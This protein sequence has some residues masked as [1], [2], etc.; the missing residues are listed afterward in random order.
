MPMGSALSIKAAVI[1]CSSSSLA[2][3][4]L[5]LPLYRIHDLSRLQIA[6]TFR[7]SDN[8][9][10]RLAGA[11][12]FSWI[13]YLPQLEHSIHSLQLDT[14]LDGLGIRSGAR[15]S[16][17]MVAVVFTR[18]QYYYNTTFPEPVLGCNVMLFFSRLEFKS[19]SGLEGRML[20]VA[21]V[22]TRIQV[23]TTHV[24][25][26]PFLAVEPVPSHGQVFIRETHLPARIQVKVGGGTFVQSGR[27]E[28]MPSCV[29]VPVSTRI[30]DFP[31]PNGSPFDLGISPS[32]MACFFFSCKIFGRNS[33]QVQPI[34]C[35]LH[36]HYT[37]NPMY[38]RVD[39]EWISHSSD[40]SLDSDG[41]PYDMGA[42][43]VPASCRLAF[44]HESH[45]AARIQVGFS[46]YSVLFRI[47]YLPN[48]AYAD[49]LSSAS[50]FEPVPVLLFHGLDPE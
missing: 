20:H 18:I 26:D 50:D 11:A 44:T 22:F 17:R 1:G 25:L 49:L 45:F 47:H 10:G 32:V 48:P 39:P 3:S 42:E 14:D 27:G 21:A 34:L 8:G 23:Y 43:P 38:I 29:V 46:R 30:E 24:S 4:H 28:R 40:P 36:L 41:G 31:N 12:L 35:A 6:T 19:G 33:S 16:P 5:P 2:F 15:I 7:R 13:Q 37:S 9:L